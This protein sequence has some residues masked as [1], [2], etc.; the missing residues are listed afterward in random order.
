MMINLF[1]RIYSSYVFAR[2]F[3]GFA[4]AE[5]N[6]VNNHQCI[7]ITSQLFPL[8]KRHCP[9][10]KQTLIPLNKEYYVILIYCDQSVGRWRQ[11]KIKHCNF[12]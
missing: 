11:R 7:F 9:S 4:I 12:L 10:I 8:G 5:V 1:N 2:L 3:C 6:I